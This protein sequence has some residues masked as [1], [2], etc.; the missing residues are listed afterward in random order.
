MVE[1]PAKPMRVPASSLMKVFKDKLF[2]VGFDD[3]AN[4][5]LFQVVF[6]G[7]ICLG[8]FMLG[9][10]GIGMDA[11]VGGKD[12]DGGCS[13]ELQVLRAANDKEE[14]AVGTGAGGAVNR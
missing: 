3:G 4:F 1:T 7:A 8:N 11:G 12:G 9:A 6:V 10:T 14:M 2:D 13:G 5:E